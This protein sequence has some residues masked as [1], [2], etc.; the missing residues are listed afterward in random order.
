MRSSAP[1][2]NRYLQPPLSSISYLRS[3]GA[4]RSSVLGG[5][6]AA[7]SPISYLLSSKRRATAF[8]LI[9][10]LV[11]ISIIAILAALA[12]PA[13]NGA[14]GSAR[15]AQ[16]RNDVQQIVAAVKAFQA[17]YGRMPTT[18]PPPTANP[19]N[20]GS[21]DAYHQGD[22]D[23]VIRI[24]MNQETGGT[25]LNS[26]GTVFLDAKTTKNKKGG[27]DLS[28]FKYYD[29]W[30]TPYAIK[31]DNNYSGKIEYFN[32]STANIFNSSMAVSAGPDKQLGDPYAATGTGK[33]D[34]CS[35]K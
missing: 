19:P 25:K 8:T 16:A 23:V 18:T 29:P 10:L 30:G 1:S 33:D 5:S 7:L 31:L 13:V 34:I 11:V 22:N 3:S 6:A 15:K 32:S 28:D 9:E 35:F 24:L 12:F 26:K 21:G 4:K 27:V 20:E 17:E 2:A 14:I